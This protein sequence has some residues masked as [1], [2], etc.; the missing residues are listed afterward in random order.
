VT[1]EKEEL[2]QKIEVEISEEK[3]KALAKKDELSKLLAEKEKELQV[4]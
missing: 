3:E 4:Y 1:K 2:K